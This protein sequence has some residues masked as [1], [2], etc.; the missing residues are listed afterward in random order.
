M[1]LFLYLGPEEFR[2]RETMKAILI[3]S[4]FTTAQLQT[5]HASSVNLTELQSLLLTPPLFGDIAPVLLTDIELL[6]L[7]NQKCLADLCTLCH[8]ASNI[9]TLFFIFSKEHKAPTPL[10]KIFAKSQQK[11]FWELSEEE[12]KKHITNFCYKHGKQMEA[13]AIEILFERISND[14]MVLEK[15]LETVLL[16]LPE[17]TKQ[18]SEELLYQVFSQSRDATVYDLFRSM[19][20]R[21]L[22]NSLQIAESLLLQ[23]SS[24]ASTYIS[25]LLYQ[26]DKL[27]QIK[28]RM[29]SDS[30]E[31]A[32]SAEFLRTKTLKADIYQGTQHY[33]LA[34]LYK[35]Q[36][37]NENY[38][39]Y[40][41]QGRNIQD[42][43][44]KQ[45]I[46]DLINVQA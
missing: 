19:A 3:K 18:I 43:L 11:V 30:F 14:L 45:Y 4:Q 44:F 23:G 35:I 46:Y 5:Y 13:S 12:K 32:C 28:D 16:Y 24:K 10:S 40:I 41:K 1:Q 37:I 7:K 15:T 39:L 8:K 42:L 29:R 38:N 9:S 20:K 17:S 34:E 22:P 21:N 31:N 6:N 27:L 2:K 33:Q 26:W 25:Q 36:K